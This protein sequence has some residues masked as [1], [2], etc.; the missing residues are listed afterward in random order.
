MRPRTMS[1]CV[2]IAARAQQLVAGHFVGM[3]RLDQFF[4]VWDFADVVKG[5]TQPNRRAIVGERRPRYIEPC[6]HL[7]GDIVHEREMRDQA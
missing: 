4:A 3:A 1:E 6:H 7:T 5:H 2:P